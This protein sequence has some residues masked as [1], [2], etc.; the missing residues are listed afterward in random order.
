VVLDQPAAPGSLAGKRVLISSGA[1]DPI[2]PADQPPRLGA[3]LR[4]GGAHVT[5][6]IHPASHGLVAADIS[7]A[8]R[9]FAGDKLPPKKSG[10]H[11]A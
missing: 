4:A 3:L 2:V 11:R 1:Q 7:G 8:L 6:E 10:N 5:L 9:W